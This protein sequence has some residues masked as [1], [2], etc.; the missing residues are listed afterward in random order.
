MQN[1]IKK[2]WVTALVII[3]TSVIIPAVIIHYNLFA[4]KPLLKYYFRN[5]YDI[6]RTDKIIDSLSIVYEGREISKDSMNL[7][8]TT[9]IIRNKGSVNIK[10][11]D[12]TQRLGLK[13]R[14]CK[15][16]NAEVD[17]SRK[18]SLTKKLNPR[19]INDSI[20]QMDN[21][22]FDCHEEVSFNVFL[23]YKWNQQP[24]YYAIGKIFGAKEIPEPLNDGEDEP[25]MTWEDYKE[26]FVTFLIEFSLAFLFLFIVYK[27]RKSRIIKKINPHGIEDIN[28]TQKILIKLYWKIGKKDFLKLMKGMVIGDDFIK[29][30]E[31]FLDA[32]K[33]VNETRKGLFFFIRKLVY[34][35]PFSR[36]YHRLVEAKLLKME[37]GRF[38][39]SQELKNEAQATLNCFIHR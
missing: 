10:K 4:P 3:I 26:L 2:Y 14:N 22:S 37:N 13:I 1:F 39:I 24:D 8:E 9:I 20:I 6:A 32:F 27:Y 23:L 35:S 17:K 18:D 29:K 30:E 15:I 16:I 19:V 34:S 28:N 31:Q 12:Y 21:L 25:F 5:S 33:K 38:I 7:R 11:D 36:S